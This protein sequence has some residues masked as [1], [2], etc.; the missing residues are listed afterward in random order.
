M[1]MKIQ[2]TCG[3][4]LDLRS[5][6]SVKILGTNKLLTLFLLFRLVMIRPTDLVM[7]SGR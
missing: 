4:N 1:L 6:F 5:T 7:F 2:Y 3:G